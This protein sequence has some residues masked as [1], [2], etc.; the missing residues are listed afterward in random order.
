MTPLSITP[1]LDRNP[2]ADITNEVTGEGSIERI[3]LLPN[4]T[5]NGRPSL[6]VVIRLPDGRAVI[7]ETTWALMRNAVRALDASPVAEADRA[8]HPYG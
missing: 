5:N 2:W 3:G 1:N 7:A 4:A 6:A 8:E